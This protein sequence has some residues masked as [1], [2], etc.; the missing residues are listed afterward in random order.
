VEL[1]AAIPSISAQQ[2]LRTYC[3]HCK[4][5]ALYKRL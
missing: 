5:A 4:K 2:T 3:D 1:E